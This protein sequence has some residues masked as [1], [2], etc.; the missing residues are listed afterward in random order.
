MC[1]YTY[2]MSQIYTNL[3]LHIHNT[4]IRNKQ[5]KMGKVVGNLYPYISVNTHI[6]LNLYSFQIDVT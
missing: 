6:P 1:V 4:Y 5:Q 2:I 3:H